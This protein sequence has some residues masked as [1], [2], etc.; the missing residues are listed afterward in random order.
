MSLLN[1]YQRFLAETG[2]EVAA[3]IFAIHAQQQGGIASERKAELLT[4]KQAAEQFALSER[5]L[6]RM[7]NDGLPVTRVGR[8]GRGTRIKPA[9]LSKA[10]AKPG[11]IL[12]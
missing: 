9:D 1:D 6:Y 8:T 10:L 7:I 11:K 5:T 3:A 2:S 12:R 4:V